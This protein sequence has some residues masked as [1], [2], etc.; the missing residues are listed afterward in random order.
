MPLAAPW[1]TASP[2]P[3][4]PQALQ[5]QTGWRSAYQSPSHAPLACTPLLMLSTMTS[6][7]AT[8]GLA[9]PAMPAVRS[10]LQAH[11]H[12]AT[13]W[14]SACPA[15]LGSPALT[16]P[17]TSPSASRST[18]AQ[19]AQVSSTETRPSITQTMQRPAALQGSDPS[20]HRLLAKHGMFAFA[21]VKEASPACETY[22]ETYQPICCGLL[23][24]LPP[25]RPRHSRQRRL[26][27]AVCVQGRLRCSWHGPV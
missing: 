22:I 25:C 13:T 5:A 6:A 19:Q 10:A 18:A 20:V 4:V 12:R 8:L 17:P 11:M 23:A 27:R 16:V 3:S 14:A 26:H 7:A 9:T 2:A 15:A 24:V 21:A 1:R